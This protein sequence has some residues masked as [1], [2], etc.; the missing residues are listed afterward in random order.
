LNEKNHW[1][2]WQHN[3]LLVQTN[4]KTRQKA[5][6]ERRE[7][8]RHTNQYYATLIIRQEEARLGVNTNKKQMPKMPMV[9][10]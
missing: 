3:S 2:I 4:N 1:Q 10:K 5:Q 9:D 6:A 7:G 8:Y